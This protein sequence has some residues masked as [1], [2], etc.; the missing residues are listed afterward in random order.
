MKG[1]PP[2]ASS[3]TDIDVGAIQDGERSAF[4]V[5]A[6]VW[7]DRMHDAAQNIVGSAE[8]AAEIC[9]DVFGRLWRHHADVAP[10]DLTRES[11]LL[12]TR[13][14]ALTHLERHGWSAPRDVGDLRH[15]GSAGSPVGGSTAG[16]RVVLAH[17][18][19][20]VIGARTLSAIDLHF[21][22]GVKPEALANALRVPSE[23]ALRRLVTLRDELGEIV[24]A[25]VLW[26]AGQPVCAN[27]AR[28]L[29]DATP[30][31]NEVFDSIGGHRAGCA[32][33]ARRL[34]A[35]VNPAS[36]F[37]ASPVKTV[38][39]AVRQ[40]ALAAIGDP[41]DIVAP[42]QADEP[43]DL[44][45]LWAAPTT[46]GP[47]ESASPSAT[48]VAP[49]ARDGERRRRRATAL[50][51]GAAAVAVF[52]GGA[53]LFLSGSGSD[54]GPPVVDPEADVDRQPA[55]EVEPEVR[56][57]GPVPPSA[58]PSTT[59]R[60]TL[61]TTSSTSTSTTS[62]TTTPASTAEVDLPPP[63]APSPAPT[64]TPPPPPPPAARPPTP[65]TS[66]PPP[67]TSP[68]STASPTTTS[69]PA[70][71]ASPTTTSAPA[72]TGAPEPSV[73]ASSPPSTTAPPTT[74]AAT[75]APTA[76]A[77]TATTAATTPG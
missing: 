8:A 62:T 12:A 74:A 75:T 26:N 52:A 2:P 41:A 31:D 63:P 30:F 42:L 9:G 14:Q 59:V 34:R 70:T 54:N 39:P 18:A 47:H 1:V 19:A 4:V 46:V 71:T 51:A 36:V 13:G 33:C 77:P 17:A 60:T 67:P 44:D 37:I 61:A 28:E 22:H 21:R 50:V 68:A 16:Q 24:A 55:E 29:D 7:L 32:E 43:A 72:T 49:T 58:P 64:G 48:T 35:L 27:L 45:D 66:A 65:A 15:G 57:L 23:E 5:L 6:D 73:T 69:A 10:S 20:T 11:L 40:T 38:V 53:A 25:F 56:S 3:A 76:T